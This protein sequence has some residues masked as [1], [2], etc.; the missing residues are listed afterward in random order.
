VSDKVRAWVLEHYASDAWF[1]QHPGGK[2]GASQRKFVLYMLSGAV[3]DR[4]WGVGESVAVLA[5]RVAQDERQVRRHLRALE[6]E[7]VLECAAQVHGASPAPHLY[8]VFVPWVPR[9]DALWLRAKAPS[10]T[11]P[12]TNGHN[13]PAAIPALI[14]ESAAEQ[15]NLESPVPE[16]P[17]LTLP[18]VQELLREGRCPSC[19]D[20]INELGE[21]HIGRFRAAELRKAG[22][23]RKPCPF[24]DQTLEA[25]AEHLALQ[26]AT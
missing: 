13:S 14:S 2:R 22:V 26:I 3:N 12:E 19:A 15:V 8:R 25:I 7:G 18:S 4:G 11:R 20:R 1:D 16:P 17:P 21:G 23:D 5:A 24:Y 9:D 6:A 10:A